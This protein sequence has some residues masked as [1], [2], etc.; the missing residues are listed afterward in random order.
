MDYLQWNAIL[1][2]ASQT[3][4]YQV[5]FPVLISGNYPLEASSGPRPD[6]MFE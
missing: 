1:F 4:D 5:G 6:V 2:Y 3:F